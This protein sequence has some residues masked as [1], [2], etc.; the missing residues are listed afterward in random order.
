MSDEHTTGKYLVPDNEQQGDVLPNKL[1]LTLKN[2]IDKA[3][4]LGFL[5][6]QNKFIDELSFDTT[7]NLDYLYSLHSSALGE[8]YEFAGKLRTVNMSK[9]GFLFPAARVLHSAMEIFE[10]D[11]LKSLS[12]KYDTDAEHITALA[13]S[14]AEL[15]YIHP[16]REGNGRTAR[17]L[18]NLV[19][20]KHFQ[21]HINFIDILRDKKDLYIKAVQQASIEEYSLMEKLIEEGLAS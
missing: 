3:E 6:T 2:E 4:F 18:A 9:G 11:I 1:G 15:L 10:K 13:I 5:K 16:F 12:D 21:K 17:L 19:A 7:F 20:Y 8:V 14:H